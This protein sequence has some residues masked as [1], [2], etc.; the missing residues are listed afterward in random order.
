VTP[1]NPIRSRTILSCLL[2][3]GLASVPALG[4]GKKGRDGRPQPATEHRSNQAKPRLEALR[5]KLAQRKEAPKAATAGIA[6]QPPPGAPAAGAKTP[7]P[8]PPGNPTPPPALPLKAEVKTPAAQAEL[9]LRGWSIRPHA[10]LQGARLRGCDLSLRDLRGIDFRGADLRDARLQGARCEG[11]RF[12]DALLLGAEIRG[13]VALD[14][15]GARL[16]PFFQAQDGDEVGS[17]SYLEAES[18]PVEA[19]GS[20]RNLVCAPDHQIYWLSGHHPWINCLGPTGRES[21]ILDLDNG[22]VH[23]LALDA[24]DRLWAV[25]DRTLGSLAPRSPDDPRFDEACSYRKTPNSNAMV[26]TSITA[27]LDGGLLHSTPKGLYRTLWINGGVTAGTYSLPDGY[28]T[29]QTRACLDP[30]GTSFILYGPDQDKVRCYRLDGAPQFLLDLPG[31]ARIQRMAAGPGKTVWATQR[32]PADVLEMDPATGQVVFSLRAKGGPQLA[33]PLAIALGPD[34]AVWFGE[35]GRIGRLDPA[36]GEVRHFPLAADDLPEELVPSRDGRLIFTLAGRNVLGAI[37]ALALPPGPARTEAPTRAWVE[38]IYRP[39]E[40]RRKRVTDAQRR[41]RALGLV[42]GALATRD[43]DDGLADEP[44]PMASAPPKETKEVLAEPGPERSTAAPS[45]ATG[46]A[47]SRRLAEL[48]VVL[49][50]ARTARILAKHGHGAAPGKSQ[51]AA[52]HSSADGFEALLAKALAETEVGRV[53][54]HSAYNRAGGAVTFCEQE[55]VGCFVDG[56]HKVPTNRF[57]VVTRWWSTPDG[58]C[59]E[60]L[61]AYPI[62]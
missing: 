40:A 25:G 57:K 59:Q 50:P 9:V 46:P 16:H 60:V 26:P 38:P 45:P 31:Q 36:T 43:L 44:K 33:D 12:Q 14:L 34:G 58:T 41:D 20:P 52:A 19:F 18:R 42:L 6:G 56:G 27:C 21:R 39:K 32:T 10:D 55:N 5:A 61:N 62:R 24:Q 11:A 48:G 30:P 15:T 3:L 7:P 8:P 29:P 4:S 17:V 13:A 22:F 28:L 54:D 1:L 47:I 2:S 51:F 35:R 23:G 49:T 37:R 53:L